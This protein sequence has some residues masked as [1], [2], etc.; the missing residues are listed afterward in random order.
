MIEQIENDFTKNKSLVENGLSN[1]NEFSDESM[2]SENSSEIDSLN[3]QTKIDNVSDVIINSS[4]AKDR[5]QDQ[6]AFIGDKPTMQE[7]IV[8][9]KN[10]EVIDVQK[11]DVN[12]K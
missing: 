8:E 6:D 7:S 10:T 3:D 2:N 4:K 9:E 12:G 1:I 5:Y 11:D